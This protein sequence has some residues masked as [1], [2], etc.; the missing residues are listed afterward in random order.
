[1]V[2]KKAKKKAPQEFPIMAKV[3]KKDKL[4]ARCMKCKENVTPTEAKVVVHI[5]KSDSGDK[6]YSFRL[7]GKCGDCGTNL[8][9]MLSKDAGTGYVKAVKEK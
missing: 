7:A 6:T 5:R 4:T 2:R 1:M 9:K 3:V 8:S